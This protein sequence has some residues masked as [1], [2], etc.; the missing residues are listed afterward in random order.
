[1]EALDGP[2]RLEG[3]EV[4]EGLQDSRTTDW[5]DLST[6]GLDRLLGPEDWKDYM[7]GRSGGLEGPGG[8]EI[9][10]IADPK[11][12]FQ[13]RS[14]FRCSAAIAVVSSGIPWGRGMAKL[15]WRPYGQSLLGISG[16]PVRV[17]VL[18]ASL[19]LLT[20]PMALPPVSLASVSKA[21]GS[22]RRPPINRFPLPFESRICTKLRATASDQLICYLVEVANLHRIVREGGRTVDFPFRFRSR[23]SVELHAKTH[24]RLLLFVVQIAIQWTS[25]FRFFFSGE[26]A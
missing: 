21:R 4:P 7:T 24:E 5:K 9:P 14:Q 6:A 2:E 13:N 23:I 19:V 1:M 8:L 18:V 12:A 20:Y 10:A 22:A 16:S 15:V 3:L 26:P 17:L 25:H 11:A